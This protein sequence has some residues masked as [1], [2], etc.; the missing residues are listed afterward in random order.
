MSATA[1][2]VFREVLEAALVVGIVMAATRGLA[3][4]NAWAA[5]GV[6]TGIAGAVVVAAF[7]G[8]VA[9]AAAGMGQELFNA[10]VLF[11]AVALLAWHNVWMSRHGRAMSRELSAVGEA[12]RSAERPI[13]VLAIVV[14][15]AVLRE[16]SEVVLFLYGI[17]AAQGTQTSTMLAGGGLGLMLGGAAGA[18]IY[19]GLI[20]FAGRYLFAITGG[21]I[22]FLAAGMAA[23]GARFL[24]QAG[25][26]PMLGQ[27]I[28]DTSFLISDRGTF[29]SFLHVLVG[30]TARPD[31]IQLLFY[32]FTL[33][34]IG[35]LMYP[36]RNPRIGSSAVAALMIGATLT[37][38]GM[39]GSRPARAADLKVYSPIVEEGEF[40]IEM[41]GN[42]EVDSADN[43]DGAQDQRYAI[44]YSPTSYWHTA[45]YGNLTK[46]A[47]GSLKYNATIWENVFQI[48]PQGQQWL[49]LGFYVEFEFANQRDSPDVL[50]WK[51]LAEK[52]VGPLTFTLNP[53]FEK[54]IGV[55]ATKSVE[56]GY[57]AR[58]KWRFMPELEPAIEA[59]GDIGEIN[60]LDP[61]KAQRH[62]IGPV[63]LGKFKLGDTSAL[64]YEAGYMFGLTSQGSP[65]GAF[66][67]LLEFEHYF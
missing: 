10:A 61:A 46:D 66:K 24:S 14:G 47:E 54:E 17:A 27:S 45:L 1:L 16:G 19:F 62:Q 40:G 2:I 13:S 33:V 30:Y 31:G 25:Y 67:W 55:N 50:E 34:S 56:F 43:K 4:R 59:Y 15:V 26:L 42:V 65:D 32:S 51:I 48:F 5:I 64:K 28:W 20:R 23:Q 11:I 6:L 18:L 39:G 52:N 49:D 41:R 63:L 7:A 22:L 44:E 58:V 37:A 9:S 3:G 36:F 35:G 53:I 8:T 21:L 12:V 57:A 38:F 29:G 60:N